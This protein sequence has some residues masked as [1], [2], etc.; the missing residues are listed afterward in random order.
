MNKVEMLEVIRKML[1]PY[2]NGC[3]TQA[4]LLAA[5]LVRL[6]GVPK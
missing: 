4:K 2:L 1:F 3:D 6:F 5:K